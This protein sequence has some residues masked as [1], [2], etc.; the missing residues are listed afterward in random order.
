ML[1]MSYK[2]SKKYVVGYLES[3]FYCAAQ[4]VLQ[5]VIWHVLGEIAAKICTVCKFMLTYISHC[6]LHFIR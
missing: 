5:L 4:N 1:H 2:N 3:H 6:I